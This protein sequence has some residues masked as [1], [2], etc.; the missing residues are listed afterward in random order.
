MWQ[1]LK[2]HYGKIFAGT[3]GTI[4]F[5]VAGT[6]FSDARYEH[7]KEAKKQHEEMVKQIQDLQDQINKLKK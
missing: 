2:N 3:T 5:S 6:L 7:Q 4:I 1:F